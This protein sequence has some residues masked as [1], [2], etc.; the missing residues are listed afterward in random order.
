[1]GVDREVFLSLACEM[2]EEDL[3]H[4]PTA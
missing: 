1:L 4:E 3:H 2:N